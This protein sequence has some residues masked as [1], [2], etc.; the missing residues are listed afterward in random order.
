VQISFGPMS[1]V[2]YSNTKPLDEPLLDEG[3]FVPLDDVV[4]SGDKDDSEVK[5]VEKYAPGMT[6]GTSRTMAELLRDVGGFGGFHPGGV[7]FAFGDGSVRFL[8]ITT[9]PAVLLQ[10]AHRADGKLID[11][12]P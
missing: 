8:S 12:D 3:E 2:D 6:P 1:Q 10:L 7:Q 4:R 9:A 11:Q 5:A